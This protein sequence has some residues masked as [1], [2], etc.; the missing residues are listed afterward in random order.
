MIRAML[1]DDAKTVRASLKLLLESADDITVVAEASSGHE[2]VQVAHEVHPDVILMDLRM[3]DGDGLDAI[4]KLAGADVDDPIPIIVFSTYNFD[5]YIYSAFE[6]GAVGFLLKKNPG[7][8]AAAL[9]SAVNANALMSPAVRSRI[10]A[11]YVRNLHGT[12]SSGGLESLGS[13]LTDRELEVIA[14]LADG[15]TN[16]QIA[17]E[18]NL[19]ENTVKWHISNMLDKTGAKDRTQL[20]LWA[21]SRGLQPSNWGPPGH[22]AGS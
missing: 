15:M 22:S 2:A 20:L 8:I 17:R 5:E 1:V 3:P 19:G 21:V 6:G 7:D 14:A 18:L 4:R 10:Q 11:D 16:R 12:T 13:I 9:R